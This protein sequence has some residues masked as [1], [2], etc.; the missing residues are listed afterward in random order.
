M[1]LPPPTPARIHG[2]PERNPMG[3][4]AVDRVL[5]GAPVRL[6][7]TLRIPVRGRMIVQPAELPR[8]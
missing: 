2:T 6:R 7:S 5:H 1:T 4:L 8:R 3:T